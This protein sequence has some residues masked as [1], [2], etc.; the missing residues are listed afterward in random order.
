MQSMYLRKY[1]V[2][3]FS[4]EISK[5]EREQEREIKRRFIVR[6]GSDQQVP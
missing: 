4:T 3:E 2:L 6:N 5:R 1:V